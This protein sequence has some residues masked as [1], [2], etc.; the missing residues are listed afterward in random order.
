MA[1]KTC[2]KSNGLHAGAGYVSTGEITSDLW[3]PTEKFV[4][5]QK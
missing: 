4:R 3:S 5:F 1:Q 2:P